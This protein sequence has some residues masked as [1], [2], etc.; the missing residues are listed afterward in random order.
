MLY[1]RKIKMIE[2]DICKD[3]LESRGCIIKEET[4]NLLI[5]VDKKG[6]DIYI[7]FVTLN[8]VNVEI[9]KEYMKIL[10]ENS[11]NHMIII[12]RNAITPAANKLIEHILESK[13]IKIEI[14]LVNDLYFNITKHRLVRPHIK[15]NPVEKQK[16]IQKYSN[17]IPMLLS[18][19]PVVKFHGFQKGDIIKIIRKNDFVCYRFV[20]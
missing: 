18:T 11:V 17:K 12:Y 8:K 15:L 14:F 19:D 2:V 20:R 7:F 9:I 13:D 6:N 10:N 1:E 16:I 5:S 3:M 4:E